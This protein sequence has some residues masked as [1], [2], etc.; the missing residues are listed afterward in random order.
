LAKMHFLREATLKYIK[1]RRLRLKACQLL[2]FKEMLILAE[3]RRNKLDKIAAIKTKYLLLVDI[4]DDTKHQFSVGS[5]DSDSEKI[6]ITASTAAEKKDW[7]E[8]LQ[9][10][11]H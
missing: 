6:V 4:P 11:S 2:L 8:A 3:P 9:E 10:V 5:K 7:L 1:K